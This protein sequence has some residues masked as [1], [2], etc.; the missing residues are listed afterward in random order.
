MIWLL[1][2][3]EVN[4]YGP[5]HSENSIITIE[6]KVKIIQMTEVRNYLPIH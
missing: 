3:K 6:S 4:T 2:L 5:Y 1:L